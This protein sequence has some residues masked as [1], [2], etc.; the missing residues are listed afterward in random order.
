MYPMYPGIKGK[1]QG[2]AKE[3]MP[4]AKATIRDTFS[5]TLFANPH[6]LIDEA[7]LPPHLV[8]FYISYNGSGAQSDLIA[9]LASVFDF[10]GPRA[11][12]PKP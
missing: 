4:A 1:T 11:V 8:R 5:G 10:P 3:R 12:L 6:Y 7:A 9:L 2:D